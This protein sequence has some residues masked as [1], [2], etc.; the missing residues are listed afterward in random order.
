M[1]SGLRSGPVWVGRGRAC[2][3]AGV[4]ERLE[5]T[6]VDIDRA[7]ASMRLVFGDG[8]EY[9]FELAEMRLHC[10]CAGCRSA[11]EQGRLAKPVGSATEVADASLHGAWGLSITW[12]DGHSAGIYPWEAMRRWCDDGHPSLTNDGPAVPPPS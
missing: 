7:T 6:V 2:H 12:G 3:H 11:R 10:P 8:F 1:R 5:V 9:R 4:D